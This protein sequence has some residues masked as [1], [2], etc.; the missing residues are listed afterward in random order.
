MPPLGSQFATAVDKA[1]GIA[2]AGEVAWSQSAPGSLTRKELRSPRLGFLYEM[3]YLRIFVSWE[4][5]LEQ[6]FLRMMCGR[7][8]PVW[9]PSLVQNSPFSRIEAAR[10]ALYG[11]REYLLWHNP[12]TVMARCEKWFQNGV[13]SQI[14]VS[15][16]ARLEWYGSI[17]HRIAHGGEQ[18]KREMDAASIGLAGKRYPGASAGR[19][20]R[21]WRRPEPLMQ[22]RW[23]R[24][25]GSELVGLA[26]QIAP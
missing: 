7:S 18:V 11:G 4:I 16:E 9:T 14:I 2:R 22:E 8:S 1:V 13:H 24:V 19:F 12:R 10:E 3:S 6:T 20:L 15:N 25:I 17:R 23:L 26:G 5:F 21:D